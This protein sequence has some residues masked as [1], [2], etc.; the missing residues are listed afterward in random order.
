MNS[1]F[2]GTYRGMTHPVLAL[3]VDVEVDT[4]GPGTAILHGHIL[5]EAGRWLF[6][7]HGELTKLE[8]L[9]GESDGVEVW[10]A[11]PE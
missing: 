2:R 3:N 6:V 5:H 8:R 11:E 9:A 10:E 4:P 7:P 1:F